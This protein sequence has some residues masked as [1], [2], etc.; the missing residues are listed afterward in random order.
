MSLLSVRSRKQL[1]PGHR[2]AVLLAVALLAILPLVT[3]AQEEEPSTPPPVA[4]TALAL[5]RINGYRT[6]AG[7]PEMVAHP[8]LMESAAG[9]VR[10]YESNRGAESLVGMGLHEQ[11]P[12]APGFTGASMRDRAK[13]AGYGDEAVTENAGFGRLEA[14]IDWYMDTVNHRLPLIHPSALDVG[15]AHSAETGFGILA[16]GLRGDRLDVDLPSVYPPSGATDVQTTWDGAETPD[17]APGIAR[18]LGYQITAAFARFQKVEWIAAELRDSAG[19][20]LAVSVPET[21]WMRAAAIIPHRPL[22]PGE[23]YTARVE[24]LVGGA[25]VTK[26]WSFTTRR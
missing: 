21:G 23:V 13:A 11:T 20:P 18:P 9:H 15:M 25:T 1:R 6:A 12:E 2:P 24:A 8:A 7:V 22:S 16:V 5:E 4:P 19:V 10:Y 14:A 26:E 3:R 17:S